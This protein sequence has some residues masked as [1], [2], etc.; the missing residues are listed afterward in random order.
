[1]RWISS[2]LLIILTFYHYIVHSGENTLAIVYQKNALQHQA[3]SQV[4]AALEKKHSHA[5]VIEI[6]DVSD[7]SPWQL[8]SYPPHA[9]LIA[10]GS[11]V[12]QYLSKT[13]SQNQLIAGLMYFKASQFHGVSLALEGSSVIQ[14]IVH[15]L[16]SINRLFI[17]QNSSL[18]AIDTQSIPNT[19]SIQKPKMI[20]REGSDMIATIRLLG[21]C[22]EEEATINDAIVIPADLPNN[23]LFEIVK[24]AWDRKITLLSVNITHLDSG[25]LMIL[26]PDYERLSDQLSRMTVTPAFENTKFLSVALNNRI[27]QH[28]DLNFDQPL[29]NQFEIILQ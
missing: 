11:P 5:Q 3:F 2:G 22:V 13:Y 4:I 6:P 8:P 12:V 26:Y 17:I 23:I 14:H 28:L 29:L 9:K 27:A 21:H 15:F 10:L 20:V 7:S 19:S 16:P 25:V 24:I 1:M 18:Q